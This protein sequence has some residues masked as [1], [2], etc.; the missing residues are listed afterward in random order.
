[1]VALIELGPIGVAQAVERGKGV[2]R[3]TVGLLY[4]GTGERRGEVGDRPLARRGKM[5]VGFLV[6]ALLE[7]LAAEQELADAVRRLNFDEL[8]GKLDGAIPM[9]RGCFEQ[10]GLLEND[11]VAGIP[12]KG[13][14]IEIGGGLH[15]VIAASK[16]P[17]KIVAEK[18]ALILRRIVRYHFRVGSGC[19]K[20]RRNEERPPR[21]PAQSRALRN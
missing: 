7:R 9:G 14:G 4:P 19:R 13:L 16:A 20:Q 21:P 10:K 5:L 8:V 1:M 15:V 17:R 12:S 2:V 11:L 18:S 6:V 3:L